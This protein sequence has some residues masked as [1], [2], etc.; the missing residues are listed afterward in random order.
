MSRR[1]PEPSEYSTHYAPFVAAVP[2]GDI[3]D[4][5]TS[6]GALRDASVA[7]ITEA[8]ASTRPPAGKWNVRETLA[9]LA[10][11]ERM[12]AYRALRI[13]RRDLS[14]LCGID[15]DAYAANACANSRALGDLR[16]ELRALRT[17]SVCLF[18][19]LPDDAWQRQDVIEGDAVSLRALAYIIV[20]HDFHH[21]QQLAD[22]FG[23]A[24]PTTNSREH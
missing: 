13:A 8:V 9:H 22:R 19:A 6:A 10:D 16:V 23:V 21:L 14:P 11:M 12:L 24:V 17:S 18:S 3:I 7:G 4:L 2:D 15:Q 5:L 20:G 1:R